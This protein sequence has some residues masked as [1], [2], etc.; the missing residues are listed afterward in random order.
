MSLKIQGIFSHFSDLACNLPTFYP[1]FPAFSPQMK[2][3]RR[4]TELPASRRAPI[5]ATP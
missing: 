1:I 2:K 3:L 4:N 5:S